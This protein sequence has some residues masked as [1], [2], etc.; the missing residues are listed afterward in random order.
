MRRLGC[1]DYHELHRASVEEPERFWPE[2]I[3]DLG[4]EFSRPWDRVV[5]VSRGPEWATWFTGARL[6]VADSCGHRWRDEP[7]AGAAGRG[8]EPLR[9]ALGPAPAPGDAA[10]GGAARAGGRGRRPGGDLPADE[11][12]G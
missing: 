4:L 5:D 6:S 11:H 10:P 7:G 3:D 1:A 8:G 12:R 9:A 2:L